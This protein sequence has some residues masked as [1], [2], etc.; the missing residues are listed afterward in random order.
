MRHHADPIYYSDGKPVYQINVNCYQGR[1]TVRWGY[2]DEHNPEPWEQYSDC[3]VAHTYVGMDAPEYMPAG[4]VNWTYG[5]KSSFQDGF[6]F[7]SFFKRGQ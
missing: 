2:G 1:S 7:M 4:S 5:I 3:Y 6:V